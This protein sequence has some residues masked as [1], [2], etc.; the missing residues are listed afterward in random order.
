MAV[1]HQPFTEHFPRA[2]IHELLTPDLLHQL[3]KGTFKDHLVTWVEDYIK[4]NHSKA[5]AESILDD[6]DRKS[7]PASCLRTDYSVPDVI[8][9]VESPQRLLFPD[10]A[11]FLKVENSSNGP[12]MIQR[13]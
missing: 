1:M 13:P 9:L 7:V 11:V 12:V 3:I 10:F 4:A 6:I 8:R 5:D 2:D